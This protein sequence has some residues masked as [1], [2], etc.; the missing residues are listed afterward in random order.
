MS[1]VS[2]VGVESVESVESHTLCIYEYVPGYGH[3]VSNSQYT[4][5]QKPFYFDF[6][7]KRL[8]GFPTDRTAKQSFESSVAQSAANAAAAQ[9]VQARRH[10]Y[11]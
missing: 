1:R 7:R 10:P 3:S 9:F 11:Y 6:N 8:V 2:R 4:N 5:T